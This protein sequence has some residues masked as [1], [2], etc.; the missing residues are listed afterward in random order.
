MRCD[1]PYIDEIPPSLAAIQERIFRP[2]C[3][4]FAV[5]HTGAEPAQELD[6]SSIEPSAA[7]LIDVQSVQVE[8]KLRVAPNDRAASYLINKITGD[9]IAPFTSRMPLTARVELLCEPKIDAIRQWIDEGAKV[10]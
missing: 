1:G 4:T 7:T 6:L 8:G 10:E 3:T 2:S 5:Y 9:G